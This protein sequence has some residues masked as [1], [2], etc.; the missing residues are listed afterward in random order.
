VGK[1]VRVRVAN[2][3]DSL[4]EEV[5]ARVFEPFFTTKATGS[6]LGLAVVRRL[7][8]DQ[9][10]RVTLD[11]DQPGVSFSIWLPAVE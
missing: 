2:D 11:R 10:G 1:G 9:G 3:G 8:E 4:L 6:G 7:I 5:A